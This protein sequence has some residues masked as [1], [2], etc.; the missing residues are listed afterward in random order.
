MGESVCTF[1]QPTCHTRQPSRLEQQC[2][3]LVEK[4]DEYEKRDASVIS[5]DRA[6]SD[7]EQKLDNLNEDRRQALA[8]RDEARSMQEKTVRGLEGLKE[9]LAECHVEI[10]EFREECQSLRD[11]EQSLQKQNTSLT[12]DRCCKGARSTE[13]F[14]ARRSSR[15]GFA[16]K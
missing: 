2:A 13:E 16:S 1:K 9:Q 4:V 14:Q 3:S 7:M 8:A 10:E 12:G 11:K 6:M 5:L 15:D